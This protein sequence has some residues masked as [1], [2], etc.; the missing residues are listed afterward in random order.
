MTRWAEAADWSRFQPSHST[1]DLQ[2]LKDA[3]VDVRGLNAVVVGQSAISGKP[4]SLFLL[5]KMATVTCCHIATRDLERHTRAADLLIAAVGK[6]GLIR[7][8]HVKDGAV[9]IDVGINTVVGTDGTRRI[10]G[11]VAFEEVAQVARVITPVP[12]GVGPV[13]VAI[14]LRSAAHAAEVQRSQP[15]RLGL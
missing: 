14:L 11:D 2:R 7:R 1:A 9:V 13:T 15:R 8:E 10:V 3:G 4:I 6:P 5:H 12:G